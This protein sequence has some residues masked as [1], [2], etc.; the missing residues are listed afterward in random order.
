MVS[1]NLI[2]VPKIFAPKFIDS[3]KLNYFAQ[4]GVHDKL[5]NWRIWKR[6]GFFVAS[7]RGI[8][9]LFQSPARRTPP[10]V[11]QHNES[12]NKRTIQIRKH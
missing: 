5:V 11:S 9:K 6:F 7:L 3:R 12:L 1:G 10:A 4:Q 8:R 2:F